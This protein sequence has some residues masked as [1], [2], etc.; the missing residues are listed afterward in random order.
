MLRARYGYPVRGTVIAG[1]LVACLAW[2]TVGQA[3]FRD[4]LWRSA[5]PVTIIACVEV[6]GSY[7]KPW[8]FCFVDRWC[9]RGPLRHP[10][11]CVYDDP[12]GTGV[13]GIPR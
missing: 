7:G 2:P 8:Q 3:T 1:V 4:D 13:R 5:Y 9:R 11:G 10:R 6:P 12:W